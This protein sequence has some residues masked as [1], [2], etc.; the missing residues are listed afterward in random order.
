[1]KLNKLTFIPITIAALGLLATSCEQP[2]EPVDYVDPF[3][4]TD[5]FAH[6]FPGPGLPFGMVH[7]SP[8]VYNKGWTYASGYQWADNSIMGFSHTHYSGV[9]MVAKGDLLI[10]PTVGQKLQ[11]TP[12][13]RENPDEG[14]RS[15]FDHADE[16]ASP[17]YYSVH[18]KDYDIEAELT[19]TKRAGMHR[20]TFPESDDSHILIDL[21][22]IL[23]RAPSG[24]SHVEFVNNNTIQGFKVS[25]EATLYFVAEFSKPFAAYGTWDGKYATPESGA[26]LFPYKSAESGSHVGA[27]VNFRTSANES[28][29]VK[30]GLSY[31]SVEGARNNLDAEIPEWDFD[32]VKSDARNAWNRELNKIEITSESEDQKQI[33]YTALY[34]SLP[35]W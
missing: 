7:L 32:R 1:M 30:G 12:G 17:G 6:M 10:M 8:D 9:G 26:N 15:R 2:K 14:Y 29:L 23:G 31:V 22:H 25:Q 21:G 33:F 4:G 11:V 35:F 18:L 27:F 3:I 28:V 5:F 13:S 34:H 20:Y 16:S 24:K 19:V